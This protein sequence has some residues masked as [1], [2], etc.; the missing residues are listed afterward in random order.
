MRKIIKF[1]SIL[2]VE[3]IV[4]VLVLLFIYIRSNRYLSIMAQTVII[5]TLMFVL[6]FTSTYEIE[7]INITNCIQ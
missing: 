5:V 2:T 1:I 3:H 6:R 7:K 4:K